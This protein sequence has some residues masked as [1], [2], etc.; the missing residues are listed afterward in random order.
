M[1]KMLSSVLVIAVWMILPMTLWANEVIQDEVSNTNTKVFYYGPGGDQYPVIPTTEFRPEVAG[2]NSDPGFTETDW[3]LATRFLIPPVEY[4]VPTAP[5]SPFNMTGAQWI[6]YSETGAGP[7]IGEIGGARGVY[8]YRKTFRVPAVAY[9]VSADVAIASDNYGWLY[10]NGVEVLE[11]EDDTK[12]DRNFQAPPSTASI[13]PKLLACDNVLAAEVQNGCGDCTNN[14]PN[15]PNAQAANLPNGPTGVIFSLT[16]DYELPDVVWQPPV[17]NLGSSGRKNGSTLPLK[18]RFYTQEG[19]LI[20][21]VQYVTLAVHEGGIADQPG[22]TVKEWK[23]GNSV[24]NM[25]FSKGNGQYIANFQTNK[26]NLDDGTYTAVV[27][28]GC[29]D[30][31]LGYTEFELVGKKKEKDPKPPKPKK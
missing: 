18:F 27:H 23:L 5:A 28:D 30:E 12:N 3:L 15:A 1:K 21:K 8:L 19:K 7:D 2:W 13:S 17:T 29:T 20:K 6:S 14:I 24:R 4:L 16:L 10:L 22:D 25:R 31:V 9:N 26:M 11:P